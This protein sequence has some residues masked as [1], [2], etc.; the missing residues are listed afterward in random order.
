MWVKRLTIERLRLLQQ[1][2]V[3]PCAN[4]NLVV[5]ANG[6]GKTSF[7]EALYL[8]GMGRSFRSRTIKEVVSRG[9][10]GLRVFGAIVTEAGRTETLG[11]ERGFRESRNRISGEG[12]Q[13]GVNVGEVASHVADYSGKPA[14]VDRWCTFAPANAG[15]GT[16]PRGTNV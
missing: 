9:Q 8:L 12:C 13:I 5:G 11:V 1:V 16:V 10:S 2:E 14:F 3:S 4:L 6:S 15:L 7:L